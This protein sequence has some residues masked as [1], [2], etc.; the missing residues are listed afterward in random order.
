MDSEETTRSI[1]LYVLVLAGS[2]EMGALNRLKEMKDLASMSRWS[3]AS[4]Y[5][6][7]RPVRM[8]LKT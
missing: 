4:A 3:L 2:P 1:A 6:L 8:S 5:A 7:S